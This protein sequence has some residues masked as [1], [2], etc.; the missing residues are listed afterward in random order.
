VQ[1]LLEGLNLRAGTRNRLYAFQSGEHR[2]A[3]TLWEHRGVQAIPFDSSNGFSPLW[4]TLRAWAE[5]ARDSNAWFD[6]LL[7]RAA[8]GPKHLAPHDRGQVAHMLSTAEGAMRLASAATPLSAQWLLVADT[9]QR[10]A[11]PVRTSTE[12]LPPFDPFESLSLDSDSPPEP[13]D[14][15]KPV[16]RPENT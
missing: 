6:A 15:R 7:S 11:K 3:I 12:G 10:Y 9:A 14:P 8:P 16:P 13:P 1:Y 2:S 4:D 5:R